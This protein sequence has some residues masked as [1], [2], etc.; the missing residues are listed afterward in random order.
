M[1]LIT[2]LQMEPI[3]RLGYAAEGNSSFTIK[4]IAVRA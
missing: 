4:H 3:V 2:Y 1:D